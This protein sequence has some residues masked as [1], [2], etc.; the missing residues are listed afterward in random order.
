[1]SERVDHEHDCGGGDDEDR[2]PLVEAEPG[3]GV[4]G[5]DAQALDPKSPGEVADEL[6]AE[7]S[8]WAKGPPPPIESVPV[9]GLGMLDG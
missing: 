6:D 1:M 3:E 9:E 2:G 4:G 8:P 7:Q 5:V